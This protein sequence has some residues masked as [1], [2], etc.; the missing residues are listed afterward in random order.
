MIKRNR[1]SDNLRTAKLHAMN[2]MPFLQIYAFF[3]WSK[4][5]LDEATICYY[6]ILFSV[7]ELMW[8]LLF[9]WR[10]CAFEAY[11]SYIPIYT[12]SAI[13]SNLLFLTSWVQR[14]VL[15]F[16]SMT[17]KN[18]YEFRIYH[19][20]WQRVQELFFFEFEID[21]NIDTNGAVKQL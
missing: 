14:S 16:F 5:K 19:Y 9:V 6:I 1:W 2:W 7:W 12:S 3:N 8:E 4:R 21:P 17:L 13:H 10:N 18:K 15:S 11:F 20:L